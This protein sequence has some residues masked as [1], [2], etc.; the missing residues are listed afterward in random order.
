MVIPWFM[1]GSHIRVAHKVAT[2]VCFL[3]ILPAFTRLL[4]ITPNSKKE[5]HWFDDAFKNGG[6]KKANIRC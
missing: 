3:D 6:G 4:E 5:G 2:L 1:V